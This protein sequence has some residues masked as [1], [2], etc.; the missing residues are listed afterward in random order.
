MAT[1]IYLLLA[2]VVYAVL[3]DRLDRSA[4]REVEK[5]RRPVAL[6]A[7]SGDLP[8]TPLE[9]PSFGDVLRLRDGRVVRAYRL[10]APTKATQQVRADRMKQIVPTQLETVDDREASSS[11]AHLSDSHRTIQRDDRTRRDRHLLVI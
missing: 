3:A 11:A 10:V 2:A 5:R 1:G 6:A 9:K 7:I 4:N 8:P